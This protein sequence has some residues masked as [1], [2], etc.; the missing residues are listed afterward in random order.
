[1]SENSYTE[2]TS[3]GWFARIGDALKGLVFG[4]LLFIVSFPL[5]FWNEGRAVNRINALE[6]GSGAVISVVSQSI[7]PANNNKLIHLSGF[8]DT[9]ETL[10]DSQFGVSEQALKLRRNVQIFQWK[11]NQ[12]SETR[13]KLGGGEETVTTYSYEKVWDDDLI[14]SDSF[15][16]SGYTNPKNVAFR[17]TQQQADEV[18]LDAF[19]LS[20]NLLAKINNYQPVPVQP[21]N[22]RR[23]I[24]GNKAS[25]Y[26]GGYYIGDNP[27]APK[28]GDLRI[29]FSKVEP[30]QISVVA[31]QIGNTFQSYAT[32]NGNSILLLENG[33]V[34]A[35]AMFQTALTENT[36]LTWILRGVGLLL[37]FIGLSMF[38]KPISVLAD[39]V[40]IL[41][42]I[43]GAGIGFVSLL[44]ALILSAITIA[45]AWLAFRPVIGIGLLVVA[46]GIMWLVRNKLKTARADAAQHAADKAGELAGE[47]GGQ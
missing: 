8:A 3:R 32:S 15:K 21:S 5:L 23:F 22:A 24:N 40:P 31:Q 12:S 27:S 6:E 7:D 11:E 10:T 29:T 4:L 13:K 35:Q 19:D 33:T 39:V 47:A 2:V 9:K 45:I 41:G 17:S 34:D 28:I 44:L 38:L 14:N 20:A 30:Q 16:K 36:I 1:M 43:A 46:F 18:S 37:M 26:D 25:H 42:D